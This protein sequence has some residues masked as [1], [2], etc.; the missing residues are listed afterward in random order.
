MNK[1]NSLV[2]VHGP[3]PVTH[4]IATYL[5]QLPPLTSSLFQGPST[6]TSMIVTYPSQL[7]LLTSL[8]LY[9]SSIQRVYISATTNLCPEF[10][11]QVQKQPKDSAVDTGLQLTNKNIEG[12]NRRIEEGKNKKVQTKRKT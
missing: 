5:S 8:A 12:K 2:L 9:I 4:M 10:L 7:S 11:S 3:S 1:S 6:V